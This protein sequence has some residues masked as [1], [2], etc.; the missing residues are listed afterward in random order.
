MKQRWEQSKENAETQ[1]AFLNGLEEQI[2]EAAHEYSKADLEMKEK[3]KHAEMW[4]QTY[5]YNYVMKMN[6]MY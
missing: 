1:L 6:G 5:P 2:N 3:L 4:Q